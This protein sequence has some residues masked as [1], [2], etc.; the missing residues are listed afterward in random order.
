MVPGRQLSM[1]QNLSSMILRQ[2]LLYLQIN[3]QPDSRITWKKWV[4][5]L[6]DTSL[7]CRLVAALADSHRLQYVTPLANGA[8]APP[9]KSALDIAEERLMKQRMDQQA[10]ESQNGADPE[11]STVGWT[12]LCSSCLR[13]CCRALHTISAVFMPISSSYIW[14]LDAA[15]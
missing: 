14:L 12:T 10:N 11:A 13:G 7:L 4:C 15:G 1:L 2:Y 9:R 8:P 5:N 3:T 6:W